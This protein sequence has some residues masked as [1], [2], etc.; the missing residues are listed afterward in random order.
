MRILQR[1]R[2][3][4]LEF[5]FP[6]DFFG[7]DATTQ[8]RLAVEAVSDGTV[9]ARYSAR[10]VE[11]LFVANPAL[12]EE[13]SE[14]ALE[15]LN[16]M[17]TRVLSLGRM[18]ARERVGEF[19]IEMTERSP[20]R[21]ADSVALRMSRYDIA[22]YLALSVETVSRALTALRM[23]G[24]IALPTTRQVQIADREALVEAM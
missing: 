2:R 11:R 5:S 15:S 8:H 1:R 4:I 23:A 17:Q 24:A 21:R 16:R 7:F 19:L 18:T 14:I 9:I 10:G 6:G 12:V 22:D 3:Q 13:F 20:G